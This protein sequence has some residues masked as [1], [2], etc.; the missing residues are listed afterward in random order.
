[1]DISRYLNDARNTNSTEDDPNNSTDNT[2]NQKED[3]VNKLKVTNN[4]DNY[5]EYIDENSTA[6]KN[7]ESF[8]NKTEEE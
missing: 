2:C 4:K 6:L 3:S 5:Y 1:M 7:N 8:N